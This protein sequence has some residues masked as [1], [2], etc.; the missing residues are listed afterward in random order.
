MNAIID[1]HHNKL[2]AAERV[3]GNLT[4]WYHGAYQTGIM[5]QTAHKIASFTELIDHI[6]AISLQGCCRKWCTNHQ[7]A[8]NQRMLRG[9]AGTLLGSKWSTLN[10]K[11]T[12]WWWSGM[13][14]FFLP[15]QVWQHSSQLLF[16]KD[17]QNPPAPTTTTTFVPNCVF[18][19]GSRKSRE[20]NLFIAWRPVCLSVNHISK[21][22]N[23][24]FFFSFFKKNKL[25]LQDIFSQA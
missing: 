23:A 20:M 18:I 16:R 15:C 4:V 24:F 1:F 11:L 2:G 22:I 8:L 12:L 14:S 5:Q 21:S 3:D 10:H 7:G 13:F 25:K 9:D 6:W 17:S 19:T